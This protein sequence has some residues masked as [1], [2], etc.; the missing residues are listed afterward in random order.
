MTD[1]TAPISEEPQIPAPPVSK[2]QR[3]SNRNPRK[4][5]DESSIEKPAA[6]LE[7][8]HSEQPTPFNEP[9]SNIS[10][11]QSDSKR[12]NRRRRGKSKPAQNSSEK[13]AEAAVFVEEAIAVVVEGPTELSLKPPGIPVHQQKQNSPPLQSNNRRLEP[14]KVAKNA[15]KIYLAEVSEE[16]VALIGDN[17]ARELARRCFRLS[18]IFLEEESRRR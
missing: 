9:E 8:A 2:V 18:E 7:P 12:K 10:E 15:W 14:E 11:S 17:D 1:Q 16:G 4:K 13:S 5:P 3:I 6:K